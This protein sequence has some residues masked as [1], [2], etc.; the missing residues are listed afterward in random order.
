[1]SFVSLNQ[2]WVLDNS[3]GGPGSL[4]QTLD[5]GR[6][7]KEVY[8]MTHPHPVNGVSFVNANVGYGVGV[9]GNASAIL[10][11]DNG[12]STWNQIGVLPG[13]APNNHI[14]STSPIVFLTEQHGYAANSKGMIYETKDGGK[15][16]ALV[17]IPNLNANGQISLMFMS[18]TQDG[19]VFD[20]LHIEATRNGGRS[21]YEVNLAP[22]WYGFG[23]P[24]RYPAVAGLY[25][26]RLAHLPM[27][28]MLSV[29]VG[30]KGLHSWIGL[31]GPQIAWFVGAKNG[32]FL[33]TDGGAKWSDIHGI[34]N[35]D[36]VNAKD[37]WAMQGGLLRT[38]DGGLTWTYASHPTS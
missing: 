27:A 25:L 8:P 30:W 28:H 11:S 5:G 16:W 22:S 1:M 18:G 34:S 2:G 19:V 9:P 33:T 38:T 23:P 4:L 14:A 29:M 31:G 10:K 12:G 7:W 37:G 32:S 6:T 17:K 36:F 24:D 35:A 15:T 21:W 20:G 26:A 13:N 3:A